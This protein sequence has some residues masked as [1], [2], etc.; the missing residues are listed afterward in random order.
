MASVSGATDSMPGTN[1]KNQ[2]ET[3]FQNGLASP[4]GTPAVD[5]GRVAAD[6]ERQAA[7]A[8]AEAAANGS[9]DE[10][11]KDDDDGDDGDYR[12]GELD[13][14]EKEARKRVM[15][16]PSQNYR[17]I[18]GVKEAYDNP[19]EEKAEILK[20]YRNLGMLIHPDFN[21]D[22]EAEEVFKSK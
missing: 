12:P 20:A 15:S 21:D 8:A 10:N 6:K 11:M 18:L 17:E 5:D 4:G 16:C 7:E 14:E 2:R 9:Q 22:E 1:G 3:L 19:I 13:E